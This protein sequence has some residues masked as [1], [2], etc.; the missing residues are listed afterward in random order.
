M[1]TKILARE[2][3]FQIEGS[4]GTFID[5]KGLNNFSFSPSSASVDTTDFDSEGWN[6]HLVASRGLEV[7]LEGAYLA[8]VETGDRDAGQEAVEALADKVGVGSLGKFKIISP[9]KT[10]YEFLASAEVTSPAGGGND[11]KTGWSVK[12]KVS[13]KV[14]KSKTA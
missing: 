3:K 10:T 1:I 8:D 7:N 12:L 9:A 13:G 5:I 6:E 4:E 2:W 14:T 11:D